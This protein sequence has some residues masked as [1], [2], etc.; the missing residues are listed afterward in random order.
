VSNEEQY[1]PPCKIIPAYTSPTL[2]TVHTEWTMLRE[3]QLST[4]PIEMWNRVIEA[5]VG[6]SLSD[7]SKPVPSLQYQL[8][9]QLNGTTFRFGLKAGQSFVDGTYALNTILMDLYDPS[10]IFEPM[11]IGTFFQIYNFDTPSNIAIALNG[12]YNN[13]NNININRIF[14]KILR[15]ALAS[16]YQY[17]GIM[18]TSMISANVTKPF[19]TSNAS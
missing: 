1:T 3:K 9:D 5:I 10:H 15:D 17:E 12:M 4:V 7:P 18:K 13:F 2:K 11:D 16:N 6:Y 8:Y 19:Q 14:F